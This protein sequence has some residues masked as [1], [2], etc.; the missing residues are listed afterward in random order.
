MG[1]FEKAFTRGSELDDARPTAA[2]WHAALGAFVAGL[3][4]CPREPG[5]KVPA[6]LVDCPW[7]TITQHGGP[8]FFLGV[9]PAPSTFTPDREAIGRI[10]RRAEGVKKQSHPLPAPALPAGRTIR[11]APWPIAARVGRRL[12]QSHL[13]V[14]FFLFVVVWAVMQ[15]AFLQPPLGFAEGAGRFARFR[16]WIWHVLQPVCGGM[17]W[18]VIGYW[19]LGAVQMYLENRYKAERQR[20]QGAS[21]EA[22]GPLAAAQAEWVNVV[23]RYESEHHRLQASVRGLC[24]ASSA[25]EGE[26]QKERKTLARKQKGE[27]WAK[28]E[29]E[30]EAQA[31]KEQK[32]LSRAREEYLREKFISDHKVPGIGPGRVVLLASYGVETAFDVTP[33]ALEPIRGI[34]PVLRGNLLAWRE[35]VLGEFR[36]DSAAA[37]AVEEPAAPPSPELQA[38]VL[39]YKQAE[40]GLRSQL[41]KCAIDLE[42]LDRQTAEDLQALLP[43]LQSAFAAVAQAAVDER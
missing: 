18:G 29:T 35:Q 9:G 31:R 17:C 7:C 25:Q 21:K 11:P 24:A 5:H 1:L 2:Q 34:G 22:A 38:L 20:R 42:A 27:A 40:E 13:A 16:A 37:P 30:R 4:P 39:R 12:S 26:F 36:Y 28:Q 3:R 23:R 32:A 10:A 41:Q 8:N 14:C 33:E 19:A 6:H 15:W 43:R